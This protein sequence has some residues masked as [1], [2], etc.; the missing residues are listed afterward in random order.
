[1]VESPTDDNTTAGGPGR[2]SGLGRLP[3]VTVLADFEAAACG[4]E[5]GEFFHV[6][7]REGIPRLEGS[8][9]SRR[10]APVAGCRAGPDLRWFCALSRAA[11]AD[12][13]GLIWQRR[14][15]SVVGQVMQCGAARCNLAF[16]NFTGLN[17]R[18]PRRL[19]SGCAI[20]Y[21]WRW[22]ESWMLSGLS[23]G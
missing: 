18:S 1:M 6:V 17:Q 15:R 20:R 9:F 5:T 23:H 11:A 3:V 16:E 4:E 13:A 14:V 21:L 10:V 22:S 7:N 12:G 19:L 8:R 2:P